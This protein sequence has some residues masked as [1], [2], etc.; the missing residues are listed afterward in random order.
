MKLEKDL[1]K[2]LSQV[3]SEIYTAVEDFP[4]KRWF[5]LGIYIVVMLD[6]V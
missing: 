6:P 2:R 4:K 5:N 3:Y 1:V